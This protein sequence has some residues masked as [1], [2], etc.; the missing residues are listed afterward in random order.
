MYIL[1]IHIWYSIQSLTWIKCIIIAVLN[2][3]WKKLPLDPRF[4][5]MTLPTKN[6]FSKSMVRNGRFSSVVWEHS[7]SSNRTSPFTARLPLPWRKKILP[8]DIYTELID[9]GLC[10]ARFPTKH[11]NIEKTYWPQISDSFNSNL[12]IIS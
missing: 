6:S 5:K 10:K 1:L 3:L 11:R 2:L 12:C 8:S 4:V 9:V 7:V